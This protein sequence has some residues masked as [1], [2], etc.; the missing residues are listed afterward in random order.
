MSF[1]LEEAIIADSWCNEEQSPSKCIIQ[2]GTNTVNQPF[3]GGESWDVGET[4]R[5]EKKPERNRNQRQREEKTKAKIPDEADCR[6]DKANPGGLLPMQC[7]ASQKHNR[8]GSLGTLIPTSWPDPVAGTKFLP[9]KRHL[10]NL[11]RLNLRPKP[12][13]PKT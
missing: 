2:G 12:S 5:T 4:S 9:E 6:I 13:V 1:F 3:R 11:K 10:E 7:V 8:L